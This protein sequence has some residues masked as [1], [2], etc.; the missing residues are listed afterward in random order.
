MANSV[1]HSASSLVG[2]S[3][4]ITLSQADGP[5]RVE[6]TDDGADGLPT[7]SP[8]DSSAEGGRGLQLVDALAARW[9]CYTDCGRTTTWCEIPA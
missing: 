9:D 6:V 1:L 7:L 3:V 8:A 2:G 4:T 5:V